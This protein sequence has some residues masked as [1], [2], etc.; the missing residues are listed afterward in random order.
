MVE[1]SAAVLGV[2]DT[3]RVELEDESIS[4]NGNRGG[5]SSNS[6]L[7]LVGV[8][9]DDISETGAD[10]LDLSGLG[11]VVSASLVDG[12]VGI[13]SLGHHEKVLCVLEALVHPA[14]VATSLP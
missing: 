12:L 11:S 4:L 9:L 14:T 6:D 10:G 5:A 13:G 1:V 3:T 8:V 7:E 2:E